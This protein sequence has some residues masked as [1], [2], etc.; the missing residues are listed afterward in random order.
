MQ[1]TYN[2]RVRSVRVTIV[3]V[4]KK[5]VLHIPSVGFLALVIQR[6]K[7]MRPIVQCTVICGMSGSQHFC[8]LSHK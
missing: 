6:A 4:E 7:R 3:A 1:C 5:L 8:A 2:V